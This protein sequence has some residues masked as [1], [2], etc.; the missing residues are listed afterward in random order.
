MTFSILQ[1]WDIGR[2]QKEFIRLAEN[3]EISGRVLDVGCG[4]GE[5]RRLRHAAAQ[6]KGSNN[7]I[8]PLVSPQHL[9]PQHH[10]PGHQ[11]HI[12]ITF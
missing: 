9:L 2:P 3:G 5:K 8:N 7:S 12:P 4:K 6:K 11:T 10:L 1:L